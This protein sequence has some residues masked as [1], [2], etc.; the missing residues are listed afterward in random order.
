LDGYNE[1]EDLMKQIAENRGSIKNVP[2]IPQ[3]LKK[4]FVTAMDVTP[5]NHIRAL[6][7]FQRWVDSSISK[8]NNFPANATVDDMRQSYMLA[9]QLGCK[10]VTVFRDS[11]IKE[12]VLVA[13]KRE[14]VEEIKK[15]RYVTIKETTTETSE[16][17]L[18]QHKTNG[19]YAYTS[20][21][22]CSS[23]AISFKEGCVTCESCGWGLCS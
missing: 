23:A 1:K 7:T 21:P 3:R 8:T 6:A 4:V 22:T 14:K 19:K 17:T 13:P 15:E 9:Y 20:C 16:G 5:E 11:S 2:Y 18:L 12:Q 10:G